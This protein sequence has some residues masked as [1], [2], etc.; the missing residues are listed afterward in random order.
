MT[1]YLHRLYLQL[2]AIESLGVCRQGPGLNRRGQRI[3]R[4]LRHRKIKP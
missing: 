2:A 1:E 4:W 3:L